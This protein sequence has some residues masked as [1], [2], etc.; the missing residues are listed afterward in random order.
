MMPVVQIDLDDTALTPL[1][2]DKGNVAAMDV[3]KD[4]LAPGVRLD[5][6]VF[7]RRGTYSLTYKH[8]LAQAI[9]V[10]LLLF[11]S[12]QGVQTIEQA[13]KILM[14]HAPD[15]AFIIVRED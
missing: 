11:P 14:A 3:I 8:T 12:L 10:L 4:M 7:I 2:A 9:E 5:A 6:K 1:S 13:D 15:L